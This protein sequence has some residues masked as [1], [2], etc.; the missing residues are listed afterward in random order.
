MKRGT[1]NKCWKY[2]KIT[3]VLFTVFVV[4]LSGCVD[5]EKNETKLR[6]IADSPGTT[7]TNDSKETSGGDYTYST[8]NVESVD[9]ITL[10]SFPVQ[11][12]V[13]AKGYLPDGCTEIDKIKTEREGNVFNINISTK[14]PKDAICTQEIVPFNETTPLDV[15]GLKA[16]NYTVNVNGV[17]ESFE[18]SVYNKLNDSSNSVLPRQEV[19][20]EANN[21]TTINLENEETFYLRLKENPTTGYSWQL[22]L[23]QGLSLSSDEYYPPE[24]KEGESSLV[25]AEGVHLWE[26]KAA[27]EGSQQVT[28]IYK[29]SWENETG[30]EDNFTLN[31]EVA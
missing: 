1:N 28:G 27:A 9:I 15:Q 24:S 17:T 23:S 19:I 14:R 25:G 29:Q 2:A 12:Q 21:G 31:V 6:N 18:L 16:G 30:T 26:I 3:T 22:N 7:V 5:E 11:I 4:I 20:T 8:A 13:I 10:E